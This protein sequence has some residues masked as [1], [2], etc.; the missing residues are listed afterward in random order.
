VAPRLVL[1]DLDDTLCDY[2]TARWTR[3]RI[4][5]GTALEA[6]D[7]DELNI[8]TVVGESIAIHPHASDHFPE[9]L[10]RHG[11]LDAGLYAEARRWYHQNRFYGLN[12]FPDALD[13]LRSVRA[14]PTITA[15]GLVTNGPSD[16][17]HD[18]IALLKLRCEV[19]FAIISGDVGWEKPHPGI[20]D[21]A[22]AAGGSPPHQTVFVGDSEECDM[23]GA[24]NAGLTPI[25]I[26]RTG[27]PWPLSA[28]PPTHTINNL[29][30]VLE[31]LD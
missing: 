4:A 11:V 7:I 25:W 15:I 30:A 29:S 5:L 31:L 6:S 13:V 19:D 1:F 14:H 27:R 8:D 2:T 23:V 16:V 9:L 24:M 17:Q 22:L 26:N 10:Q 28:P 20:F 12:L 21:A 3:L 18:K